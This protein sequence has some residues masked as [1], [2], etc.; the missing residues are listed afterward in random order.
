MSDTIIANISLTATWINS[1]T[2]MT[3][4]QINTKWIQ[5][6]QTLLRFQTNILRAKDYINK[7][8]V[9][10]FG[11]SWQI[12]RFY[13]KLH[14]ISCFHTLPNSQIVFLF[15]YIWCALFRTILNEIQLLKIHCN[16]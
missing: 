15:D 3:F 6:L 12:W 9:T 2:Q 7:L 13:P 1:V 14:H 16:N 8:I 4:G 10:V 5:S 11:P